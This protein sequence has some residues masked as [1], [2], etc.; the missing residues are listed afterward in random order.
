MIKSD[1]ETY[2]ESIYLD[3]NWHFLNFRGNYI[4]TDDVLDP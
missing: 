3:N 1:T 4:S 2:I